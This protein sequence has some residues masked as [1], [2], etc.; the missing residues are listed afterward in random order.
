M[1]NRLLT[2]VL[3][4]LVLMPQQLCA[5][6]WVGCHGSPA[7]DSAGVDGEVRIDCCARHNEPAPAETRSGTNVA[8][9]HTPPDCLCCCHSDPDGDRSNCP[10][11]ATD[12]VAD[13][14]K[15]I[16]GSDVS[17]LPFPFPSVSRPSMERSTLLDRAHSPPRA[18]PVPLYITFCSLRN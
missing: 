13:S 4:L 6:H 12:A 11:A 18:Q 2:L 16:A 1:P 14:P 7:S 3:C 5:C 15:P 8:V 9:T 10:H 17:D